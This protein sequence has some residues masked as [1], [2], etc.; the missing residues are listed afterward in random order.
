M[1]IKIASPLYILREEASADLW[2]VME[3]LAEIGFDGIE[4]L[5]LFGKNPR[6]IR[7]KLDSLG[8]S[9]L[10]D[11]VSL[12]D[13]MRDAE[14]IIED[15]N[16]MGCSY[17]TIGWPS[18]EI[19][20]SHPDFEKTLEEM[21]VAAAK[22]KSCGMTP[23]YHNHAFEFYASETKWIEK[24]FAAAAENGLCFEPDLG[25]I[26]V[27]GEAPAEYLKK[28]RAICPV[29]HLKDIYMET[30]VT[31]PDK[32]QFTFR[33]TGFGNLNLPDLMPLCL[34][35]KP[36]WFVIDHDL[37]YER[38]SYEDLRKSLEYTKLLL[39]VQPK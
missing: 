7:V 2:K 3:R 34:D 19:G 4:F 25:W 17:L 14:Q 11:H 15:R 37:A 24:L 5:G 32:G 29:I 10:G 13:L 22:I 16:I 1:N 9:A 39:E 23:L 35:C 38:D 33:P 18:Q 20:T 36:E 28:H 6:E 27:T 31:A 21:A 12:T 30:P 26:A 8:M